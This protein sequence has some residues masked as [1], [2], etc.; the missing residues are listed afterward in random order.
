[1]LRY[2]STCYADLCR[3]R[4]RPGGGTILA[5][6]RHPTDMCD[7]CSCKLEEKGPTGWQIPVNCLLSVDN[8]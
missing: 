6:R 1:M 5:A 7:T 2:I 4:E 3:D 8:Q